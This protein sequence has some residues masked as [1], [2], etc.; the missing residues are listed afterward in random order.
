MPTKIEAINGTNHLHALNVYNRMISCGLHAFG[1]AFF[2]ARKD[3]QIQF[4]ESGTTRT[5]M[6][7]HLPCGTLTPENT[8]DAMV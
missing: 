3:V 2:E 4:Q 7:N 5:L 8:V 6:A 1:P